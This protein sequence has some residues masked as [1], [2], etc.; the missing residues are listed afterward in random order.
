LSLAP[1]RVWR[2]SD[3]QYVNVVRDVFGVIL[4]AEVTEAT[5]TGGEFSNLSEVVVVSP[6]A[7]FAYQS[8]AR[9]A[10]LAATNAHAERFLQCDFSAP[11]NA[12]VDT[13]IRNRIARAFGRPLA[14]AEASNLLAVYEV[15][16][17]ESPKVG[18]RLLLEAALQSPSFLYR[19]EIG[20]PAEGGARGRVTLTT[21]ELAE[22]LSFAFLDT[23][24][25]DALWQKAADGTLGAPAVLAAEVDRLLDLPSVQANLAEKAGFWLGV[26]RIQRTQKD[27]Q[28]FPEFTAELKTSLHR[29]AQLFVRDVLFQ[30]NVSDLLSSSTVYVDPLLSA[31]YGFPAGA[32][33]E[34]SPVQVNNGERSAGILTQP[35][36]LAATS[37]R[38]TKGDPIHRGLFIYYAIACGGKI[39][40]PP[41][42]ALDIA[43]D[44]NQFPPNSTERELANLRAANP[45]CGSCHAL[46]DPLGL[47]MESYDPIGRYSPADSSA[48][49]AGLGP[50]LDGPLSGLPELAERLRS[51]RRVS[52]CAAQNLAMFTLGRDLSSDQSCA[53]SSVKEQFAKTGKFVDFYR[54]LVT[55]P[56]FLTRDAD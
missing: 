10:A 26:E 34:A 1:A 29:S 35:G 49:I 9:I 43:S 36:I 19:T 27:A 32:G 47:A 39:P 12:C 11:S 3:D 14:D 25:D 33:A 52:D 7:A 48:Q 44:P 46:F 15:G 4:P 18:L 37:H 45:T 6:N 13:F 8:A 16:A 31:V 50:E 5:V 56:A 28:V 41:A 20:A 54:A 40:S 53:L 38:A 51:G 2:L 17:K 30:G 21:Y 42:G 55:S 23:V 22:A 24:P